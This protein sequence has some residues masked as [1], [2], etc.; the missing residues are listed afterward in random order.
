[1]VGLAQV[2]VALGEMTCAGELIG[3]AQRML[4]AFPDGVEDLQDRLDRLGRRVA[5]PH[6]V[7]PRGSA[8]TEREVAVLRLLRGTMSLREIGQ[9]LYVSPN[10]VKSHAQAIYRKLGVS[11]R[12]DAVTRGHESGVL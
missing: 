12:H 9:E 1:M 8:L 5:P 10:T 4:A 11:T 3:D 6:R 7:A 2:H